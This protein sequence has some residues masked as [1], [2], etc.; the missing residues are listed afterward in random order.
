MFH[1]TGRNK[2]FAWLKHGV[3]VQMCQ[4]LSVSAF[5]YLKEVKSCQLHFYGIFAL[6]K[7][8]SPSPEHY[9]RR[10]LL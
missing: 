10:K 4:F 7:V 3:I 9:F 1:F 6:G 5:A 2:N 8:F